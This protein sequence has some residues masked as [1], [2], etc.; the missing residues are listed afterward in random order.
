ML[1]KSDRIVVARQLRA[2]VLDEIHGAHVGQSKSVFFARDYVFWPSMTDQIKGKVSSCA[3]CNAFR[4][5]QQRETLH[6]HNIPGLPWQVVGL[7]CLNMMA[8]RT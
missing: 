5:R 2:E 1:F 6:S 4:N 3:V 8:K 7:I